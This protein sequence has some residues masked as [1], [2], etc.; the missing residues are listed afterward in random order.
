[1]NQKQLQKQYDKEL[2]NYLST[3]QFPANGIPF[4]FIEH[5]NFAM[6]FETPKSLNVSISGFQ[7]LFTATEGTEFVMHEMLVAITAMQNRTYQDH[8]RYNEVESMSEYIDFLSDLEEL[9]SAYNG[10]FKPYQ[11]KLLRKYQ[12]LDNLGVN[13]NQLYQ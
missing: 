3:E 5:K 12:T 11:E 13:K 7:N 8:R 4:K 2:M 10:I 6:S 1:M 9:T